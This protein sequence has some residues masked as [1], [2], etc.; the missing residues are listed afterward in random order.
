MYSPISLVVWPRFCK[1]NYHRGKAW[2]CYDK[3]CQIRH[4]VSE[5]R[6]LSTFSGIYVNGYLN[7]SACATVFRLWKNFQPARP[8]VYRSFSSLLT[9]SNKMPSIQTTTTNMYWH[10]KKQT[11]DTKFLCRTLPTWNISFVW[12]IKAVVLLLACWKILAI[13]I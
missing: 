8:A 11:R 3:Q 4:Y 2:S 13:R 1:H 6:C 9:F 5:M 10:S 12:Y 7:S